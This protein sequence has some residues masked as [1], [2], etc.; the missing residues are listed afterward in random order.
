MK[1]RR[2]LLVRLCFAVMVAMFVFGAVSCKEE[3][4]KD[5]GEAGVYYCDVT[6]TNEYL[7]ELGNQAFT[8][9]MNT[10]VKSGKYTYNEEKK[11]FVLSFTEGMVGEGRLS[12]SK[13]EFVL[14]Y[15]NSTFTFVRKIEY[16]VT[17]EVDGGTAIENQTVRNGRTAIKP[18]DPVKQGYKFIT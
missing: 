1:T 10:D 3:Q 8:L 12:D 7:L 18:A 11:A 17:F 13:E 15:G 14:S 9:T 4:P 16:T 5:Y 2:H 6:S